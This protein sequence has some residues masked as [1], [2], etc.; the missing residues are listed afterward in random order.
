MTATEIV[1]ELERLGTDGYKKVLFNHG[2]KVWR[3]EMTRATPENKEIVVKDIDGVVASGATWTLGALQQAFTMAGTGPKRSKKEGEG[4]DTIFLLSDGGP[5]NDDVH[6]PVPME[7][8]KILEAVKG[9]NQDANVV[10]HAI[11]V[12]TEDVGTFFLK[13]IAAQNGGVFVER[14]Q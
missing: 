6:E 7:P 5:T 9:W 14:R 13:Q 11:A 12:D 3:P 8:E 4:I 2:V 1:R 10:I